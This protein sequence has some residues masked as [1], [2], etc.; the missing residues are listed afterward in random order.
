M[1]DLKKISRKQVLEELELD[2]DTLSLYEHELEIDTEP[3]SKGLESFTREDI[4][5][6]K[7]FHK[8]R[9]SGL[10][11]NEMKLLASFSEFMKNIDLEEGESIKS[12]LS[13]SPV[14]RLKQSLNLARQE[15]S[16]LRT[17]VQELEQILEQE[18]ENKTSK[19]DPKILQA[20]LDAKEKTITNLD[21]K[22][23]EALIMKNQL[24]AELVIYKGGKSVNL[25]GKKTK[26]LHQTIIQKEL[27]IGELKKQVEKL[28]NELQGSQGESDEL[29][30]RLNLMEG[31]INEIENEIE[32]RYQ[33]QIANLRK[34]IES[35]VDK[36]QKE[37]ETYYVQSNDQRRKEL[38]TLQE[39]HEK[40]IL[41]LKQKI[42]DQFEEIEELKS[43]KNPFS[44]LL[45]IG[46]GLR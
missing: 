1:Q 43:F 17:K 35:L 28:I 20:E 15:L 2:N 16:A 10:T 23:A 6:I 40:E 12:L 26:E 31:E 36:K 22:L 42:K 5:S 25:K 3:D 8:L 46:S 21:R 24:E 29:T 13:L 9:E 41:R 7:I 45:K 11:Y 38:L 4:E 18:L 27:E 32:E 34:Q 37:W 33:E 19:I 39:K 30:E 44:G 14:Y